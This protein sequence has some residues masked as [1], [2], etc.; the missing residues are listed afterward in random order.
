MRSG[1][2]KGWKI[3]VLGLAALALSLVGPGVATVSAK[4]A[5]AHVTVLKRAV[6]PAPVA[7]APVAAAP[8]ATAP[9]APEAVAP[10]V[11]KRRLRRVKQRELNTT[12]MLASA[13]LIKKH[14]AMRFGSEIEVEIVGRRYVARIERHFHPEG[15]AIK[16][17][18]HHPGVSLFSIE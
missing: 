16:P 12:L 11:A 6:V 5:M 18:G 2:F 1:G 10:L 3:G 13:E 8:V 9:A 17:W 14:H 7:A 15:G 4:P